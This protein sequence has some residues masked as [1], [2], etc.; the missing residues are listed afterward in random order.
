M[1]GNFLKQTAI[2]RTH[3][4][5]FT[6]PEAYGWYT[7]RICSYYSKSTRF[8]EIDVEENANAITTISTSRIQML[9]LFEVGRKLYFRNECGIEHMYNELS[10]CHIHFVWKLNQ[11]RKA[12]QV[13]AKD[14]RGRKMG[15]RI[16]TY[17]FKSNAVQVLRFEAPT[18]A[19]T[20]IRHKRMKAD[21]LTTVASIPI[22]SKWMNI[23][24]WILI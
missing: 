9:L 3:A 11:K 17:Q 5:S 7:C 19:P 16:C 20:K 21:W 18:T 8:D 22:R 6:H 14:K 13:K 15:E 12:N 23:Y 10:E 4:C 1:P 24:A 2:V